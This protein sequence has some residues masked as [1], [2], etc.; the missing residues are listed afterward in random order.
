MEI[1]FDASQS[2]QLDAIQAAVDLFEGQPHAEHRFDVPELAGDMPG[3]AG[4]GFGNRLLLGDDALLANLQGIQQRHGLPADDHLASTDFSVE[5][6]T[7]TGKTY[8]YLRSIFELHRAYG[9]SKFVI[10]VPSVAIREG[11]LTSLRLMREHFDALYDKPPYDCWVYDA[12]QVSRLRQFATSSQLQILVINIDAFNKQANNVIHQEHD[13]LSGKPIALIQQACPITILDEPQNMESEKSREAIASLNPLCTLRYSATH[14]NA[15]HLIYRLDPVRAYELGLVKRIE[16]DSVLEEADFNRPYLALHSIKRGARTLTAR[17]ELDVD[18]PT[19]VKRKSVTLKADSDLQEMANGREQYAGYRVIEIQSEAVLFGNGM[20]IGLGET[21]GNARDDI[22]RV[23]VRNTI[24][25]H[26]EKEL[27]QQ[28]LPAERRMKVLSLFFIDKV[29]HYH[30]ADGKIRR[31]FIEEYQ[32]ISRDPAFA[33]LQ[34]LP[35]EQVHNGY[36]AVS[37]D[38]TP[39]DTSGT[40]QADNDAYELIMRD[41][42]RLLQPQEPL[43]FI[44]SHSA[45]REGWDNPNVFQICTL[46]EAKSDIRK[47]QEIGRGLRLPVMANGERC[48]DSALNRLT[49]IANESYEDFACRLQT[50]IE[51]ETGIAFGANR[52]AN[53]RKRRPVRL[54]KHWQ[55]E[56]FMALWERIRPRTRYCVRFDSKTLVKKA[57]EAMQG[58]PAIRAPRLVNRRAELALDHDGIETRLL[59]DRYENLD[60]RP[61]RIPDLLGWL[62][63]ETELTRG[64]LAAVLQGSGRLADAAV[65]PQQFLDETLKVIRDTLRELMVDGI[66]YEL[67]GDWYELDIFRDGETDSYEERVMSVSNSIYDGVEFDSEVEH[68]FAERLDNN[69]D[70]RLFVKLPSGFVINTPLGTYNPDWAIVKHADQTIYMVRETKAATGKL[71]LRGAEHLKIRCG[72]KHFGKLGVDFNAVTDASQV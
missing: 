39:K 22:M 37:R 57:A 32:A 48:F 44:F 23:Q 71:D 28:A 69:P 3:L 6:E 67:V 58:M 59:R 36:F 18:T 55:T 30:D 19:G 16:V 20:R 38:S 51:E 40:T 15:Y 13:R 29:A 49:V 50:E 27:R 63:R 65:N 68:R 35:V 42:E 61:V 31:W 46:A 53:R 54:K 70:I 25:T 72:K 4:A 66:E 43:R 62:Q 64:T 34:P 21:V 14:R 47:R 24:R 10:V 45:L 33:A 17:M 60:H 7:G 41:K 26:F 8:I 1:R 52:I 11:V 56:E 5:M 2:Y 9:F 12:K